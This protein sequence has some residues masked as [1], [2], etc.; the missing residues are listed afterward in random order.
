MSCNESVDYVE[1][2]PVNAGLVK[3]REQWSFL[4]LRPSKVWDP[5][6]TSIGESGMTRRAG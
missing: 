3:S 4:R 1:L 6:G 5:A 2:N